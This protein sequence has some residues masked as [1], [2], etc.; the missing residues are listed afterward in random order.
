MKAVLLDT[1]A[2]IQGYQA[3]GPELEQYTV[4]EVLGEVRDDF[5]RARIESAVQTG[6]LKV[7]APNGSFTDMVEEAVEE[8][9]EGGA[10]SEADTQLLS[11]GLQMK[12]EGKQPV[13]VSDDYSVQN[14]ADRLGIPYRGLATPG[15][16]R[17]LKWVVYCPGCGRRFRD[18]RPGEP[19]PVCGT[20][21][22]RKPEK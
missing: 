17:R 9:G 5:Q 13:I 12:A 11:L 2:L 3:A 18:A 4:P 14:I 16:R 21:L 1:S 10:L 8:M 22:K 20:R 15:I 6:S 19:C 7:V